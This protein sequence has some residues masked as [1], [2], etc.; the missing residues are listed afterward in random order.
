MTLA[1]AL[2][3]LCGLTSEHKERAMSRTLLAAA[4]AW[5]AFSSLPVAHAA[6]E[7]EQVQIHGARST[8]SSSEFAELR[9]EYDLANGSRLSIE[10]TRLRPM[11]QIDGHDG[12]PLVMTGPTQFTDVAGQMR[13]DLHAAPNGNVAG[14]TVTYLPHGQTFAAMRP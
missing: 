1:R 3:R 8:L 2:A 13:V 6:S 11:A 12:V 9:G 14:L 5:A 7:T 10:G 4:A